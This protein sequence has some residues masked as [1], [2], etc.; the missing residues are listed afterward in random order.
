MDEEERS[1]WRDRVAGLQGLITAQLARH[2]ELKALVE[3]LQEVLVPTADA[4]ANQA[5]AAAYARNLQA[6]LT[7]AEAIDPGLAAQM[8][9]R[10]LKD[11]ENLE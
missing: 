8:D 11:L 3:A 6:A 4:R 1:E 7:A 5:L 2:L 10:D 9:R